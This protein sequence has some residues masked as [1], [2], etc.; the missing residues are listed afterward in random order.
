M[1]VDREQLTKALEPYVIDI[2]D[3]S[4]AVDEVLALLDPQIDRWNGLI[5]ELSKLAKDGAPYEGEDSEELLELLRKR[6]KGEPHG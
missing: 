6:L 2:R 5:W 1:V 4:K 3:V